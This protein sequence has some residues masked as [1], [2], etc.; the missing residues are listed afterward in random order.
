MK[1]IICAMLDAAF[2]G[3]HLALANLLE[4]NGLEPDIEIIFRI[5]IKPGENAI[6]ASSA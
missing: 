3:V 5:S 6:A 1:E 4:V 2:L